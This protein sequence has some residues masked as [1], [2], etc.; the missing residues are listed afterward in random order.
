MRSPVSILGFCCLLVASIVFKSAEARIQPKPMDHF[1]IDD[2]EDDTEAGSGSGSGAMPDHIPTST[3]HALHI[4]DLRFPDDEDVASNMLPH[5]HKEKSEGSG[6][7]NLVEAAVIGDVF[8]RNANHFDITNELIKLDGNNEV[9][10]AVS[11]TPTTTATPIE[12]VSTVS[13]PATTLKEED[14]KPNTGAPL[15]EEPETPKPSVRPEH[16]SLDADPAVVPAII[17]PEASPTATHDS[18]TEHERLFT[19]VEDT[20]SVTPSVSEIHKHEQDPTT[21]PKQDQPSVDTTL[22]PVEEVPHKKKQIHPAEVHVPDTTTGAPETTTASREEIIIDSQEPTEAPAVKESTTKASQADTA[23]EIVDHEQN[24]KEHVDQEG[25]SAF[26]TPAAE[27][28]DD[29]DYKEAEEESEDDKAEVLNCSQIPGG[30]RFSFTQS[31]SAFVETTSSTEARVTLRFIAGCEAKNDAVPTRPW[32]LTNF[33]TAWVFTD[34]AGRSCVIN[35]STLSSRHPPCYFG[36]FTK[37]A[38]E[39]LYEENSCRIESVLDIVDAGDRVSGS[40]KLLLL[41]TCLEDDG[42]PALRSPL[43]PVHASLESPVAIAVRVYEKPNYVVQVAVM[44]A[45][46]LPLVAFAIF[47]TV[48]HVRDRT[49]ARKRVYLDNTG[50]T[51]VPINNNCTYKKVDPSADDDVEAHKVGG[52]CGDDGT[53]EPLVEKLKLAPIAAKEEDDDDDDDVACG[54][55]NVC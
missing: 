13:L 26:P 28:A 40:F 32:T 11:M 7:A 36:N 5:D 25:R 48:R 31:P 38:S 51:M 34:T 46:V 53:K 8:H 24:A 9:V 35:N 1:Y 54:N 44:S 14:Q 37:L 33:T 47:I 50:A 30:H 23:N 55:N 22:A 4:P 45:I 19:P 15:D 3:K 49:Q 2:T 42:F 16:N 12:R 21:T 18:S 43:D 27:E 20:S 29:D 52:G 6:E 41:Y 39:T 17:I 10:P